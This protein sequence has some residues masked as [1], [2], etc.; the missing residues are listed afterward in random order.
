LS[1][2][3]V[4]AKIIFILQPIHLGSIFF[5]FTKKTVKKPDEISP[6]QKE[7]MV[8]LGKK[9][10]KLRLDQNKGYKPLAEEMRVARNTYYAIEE[11]RLDFQFS[12][13]YQI[14]LYYK[15]H[16]NITLEEIFKDL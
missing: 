4:W 3:Y 13:L 8:K 2:P 12:S 5:I 1:C 15:R 14:L 7:F 10:K 16:H 6:E 9:L 11:G